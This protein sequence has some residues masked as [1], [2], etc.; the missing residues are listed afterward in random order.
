V[1]GD[2]AFRAC[3][4][5]SFHKLPGTIQRA[6]TGRIR[7]QG[8]VRVERGNR[9]ADLLAGAMGMPE[10]GHSVTMTVDGDHR[11]D[12]MIWDRQFNGRRFRSCFRRTGDHLIES[13]GPFHLHLRLAV[14]DGRLRYLLDRV[15]LFGI[16]WPRTL[17]PQLN[18]WE[19]EIGDQYDFEVEVSLPLIGR[20]VRYRGQ[21]DLVV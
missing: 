19:G 4:G 7:L 2:D 12:C 21:L 13:V 1:T 3:C 6:H 11:P 5:A 14:S 17:A 15:S 9:L 18:A 10:A 16:P 8:Q 20:L